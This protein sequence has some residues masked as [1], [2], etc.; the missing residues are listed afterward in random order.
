MFDRSL[1]CESP[2]APFSEQEMLVLACSVL[3]VEQSRLSA[4]VGLQ[5]VMC[6]ES[7]GKYH[8]VSFLENGEMKVFHP[9]CFNNYP[10]RVQC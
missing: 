1:N 10:R 6:Q 5:V 7:P 3:E 4:L 8:Y 2:P 9:R